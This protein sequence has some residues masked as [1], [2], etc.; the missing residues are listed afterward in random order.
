LRK[1]GCANL[2]ASNEKDCMS[3]N[4][5]LLAAHVGWRYV[6]LF[7]ALV[8]LAKFLIGWVGRGRWGKWDHRI[9]LSVPI[10]LDIQLFLGAVFWIMLSAWQLTPRQ[11]FEHP[12][13]ML[14]AV[15]IGHY[16][17]VRVRRAP[18]ATVKFRTGFLGYWVATAILGLGVW[19]ITMG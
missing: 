1:S 11:A 10:V 19:R 7:V 13:T 9:G 8:A 14:V 2:G 17:W 6:V 5:V 16:T 18:D 3:L 4:E 15:A 12:L